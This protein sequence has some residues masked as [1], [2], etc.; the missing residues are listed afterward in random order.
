MGLL[1]ICIVNKIIYTLSSSRG[2]LRSS[3]WI[4]DHWSFQSNY[5]E[6]DPL[7]Y[8]PNLKYPFV[9]FP[10][11]LTEKKRVSGCCLL[12]SKGISV[13]FWNIW[14]CEVN[15]CPVVI[16]VLKQRGNCF[17]VVMLLS[18]WRGDD[19]CRFEGRGAG[20]SLVHQD[21]YSSERIRDACPRR[22]CLMWQLEI[23]RM[24]SDTDTA[25]CQSV[26]PSVTPS[27]PRTKPLVYPLVTAAEAERIYR[28]GLYFGDVT[29][30]RN[31]PSAPPLSGT[32]VIFRDTRAR[33]IVRWF[34]AQMQDMSHHRMQADMAGQRALKQLSSGVLSLVNMPG[35]SKCEG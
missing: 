1:C 13:Y 35:I 11:T 14:S 22:R 31:P 17:S 15:N 30:A 32:R 33:L 10:P 27:L 8:K 19:F 6:S 24:R 20:L 5:L 23:A 29:W 2:V 4:Y 28:R 16:F 25:S 3:M 18:K 9:P 12:M 7:K 34:P 26:R 21:D